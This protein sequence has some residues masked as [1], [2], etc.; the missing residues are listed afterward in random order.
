MVNTKAMVLLMAAFVLVALVAGI[1]FSQLA[2]AQANT[3]RN[4]I[5]QTPQGTINNACPFLQQG[6]YSY[7]SGQ[8]GNSY[9]CSGGMGMGMYGRFR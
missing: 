3:T 4:V 9:G 8:Y 5:S 6:C 7:G 1:A 2:S